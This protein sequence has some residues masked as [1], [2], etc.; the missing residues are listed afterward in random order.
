MQCIV[1]IVEG[2]AK[3]SLR[4]SSPFYNHFKQKLQRI[5]KDIENENADRD[6]ENLFYD[7]D[8]LDY[9]LFWYIR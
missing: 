3:K 6:E 9:F 7:P 4:G 2:K 8:L 1:F 5:K